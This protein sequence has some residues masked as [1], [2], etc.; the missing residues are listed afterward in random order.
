MVDYPFWSV[1]ITNPLL[2]FPFIKMAKDRAGIEVYAPTYIK[3]QYIKRVDKF[4][5]VV[6][7]AYGGY[8]F[9]RVLDHRSVFSL[10][11]ITIAY[12]LLRADGQFVFIRDS[13]IDRLRR[14]ESANQFSEE[15]VKLK[16]MNGQI[17]VIK[18]G[19]FAGK[20]ARVL[21]DTTSNTKVVLAN[22]G[23]K[24]FKIPL[25][26]FEELEDGISG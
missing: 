17:V 12:S 24:N 2:V 25:S 1:G 18:N 9:V 7:P 13:E 10:N 23:G 4:K 21:E 5:D 16:F 22:V 3:K 6:R 11:R 20:R 19:A 26:F 15:D 8:I 14:M